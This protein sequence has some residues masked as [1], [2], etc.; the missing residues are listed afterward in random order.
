MGMVQKL[1]LYLGLLM[2]KGVFECV[3]G[4]Y[5]PRKM[6]GTRKDLILGED[7]KI[8]QGDS[9]SKMVREDCLG[10][11]TS[12]QKCCLI[13][14]VIIVFHKRWRDQFS[15][16]SWNM[17]YLIDNYSL[18]YIPNFQLALISIQ[19]TKFGCISLLS[20]RYAHPQIL[21]CQTDVLL[22]WGFPLVLLCENPE[23]ILWEALDILVWSCEK[24]NF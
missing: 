15:V 12:C 22:H 24:Y 1:I 17:S 6:W 11:M 5:L 19:V 2:F 3:C 13:V 7:T 14:V 23:I 8:E 4:Y 9:K 16:S 20:W 18:V 10:R 21:L